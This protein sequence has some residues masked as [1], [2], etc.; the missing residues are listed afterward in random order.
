MLVEL[1]KQAYEVTL[2]GK[3]PAA[4]RP[5]QTLEKGIWARETG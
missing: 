4:I 5:L 1:W 2:H 3:Y